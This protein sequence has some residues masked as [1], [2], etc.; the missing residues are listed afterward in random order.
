MI[1]FVANASSD[2]GVRS[3][4]AREVASLGEVAIAKLREVVNEG[5]LAAAQAAVAA[6]SLTGPHGRQTLAEIAEDHPDAGV[7][8]LAR[9][10]LG[11]LVV[12]KH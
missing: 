5:P 9:L 4:A 10:A 8:T 6:L 7:R 1:G 2:R 3:T 12:D 11:S